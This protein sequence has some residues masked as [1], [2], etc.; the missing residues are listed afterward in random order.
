MARIVVTGASFPAF[1][2]EDLVAARH[3]SG[4]EHVACQTAEDVT[5]AAAG[6]DVLLVQFAPVTRAAIEALAPGAAIVR[7]GIGLDNIDCSAAAELGVR[8]AYVPDYAT[9]EVADHSAALLLAALRKLGPLSRSVGEGAWNPVGVAAPMPSFRQSTVGLVGFGRIA[10]ELLERLKPF[11]FRFV[12]ADPFVGGDAIAAAGA[13]AV[14]LDALVAC[15]D[16]ISLHLPLTTATEHLFDAERFQA[17]KSN[18]VIVNTAR[19]RLID[20]AA[21]AAAI[22]LGTIAGAALDVFED[23]PLPADSP[24]RGHPAILL[25]PHVAWYSDSSVTRVQDLA[26]DEID[27]HLSGRKARCPAPTR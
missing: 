26:A 7:Y 15:A 20:T 23:E 16:A 18:A 8:V 21:L 2:A 13:E 25:T 1:E 17:M 22:R 12:V 3:A 10:R 27:R 5:A 14:S 4:L 9:G 24:L 11:G 19:G 6:A